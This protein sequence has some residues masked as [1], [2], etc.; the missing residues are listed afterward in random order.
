VWLSFW[1]TA[2]L[3]SPTFICTAARVKGASGKADRQTAPDKEEGF[4]I[5]TR[6]V[7]QR[8]NTGLI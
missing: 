1:D 5:L 8:Y 7:P 3:K 2:G 4:A 6:Q